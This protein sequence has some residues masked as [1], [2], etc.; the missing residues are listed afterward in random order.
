MIKKYF[1]L[2]LVVV[3]AATANAQQTERLRFSTTVGTGVSMSS[4]KSTPFEWQV[5]GHY[6]F[7]R[8]FSAG[9]GT[10]LSFYEK[11]LI[12]L[13]ADVKFAL[14]RP[15]KFT[16]FLECGA[17]Y[18]FA[19]GKHVK[20]GVYLNP[21]AGVQYSVC[22]RRILFIALGYELQKLE[23]LK[24]YESPLFTAELAEK[25]NHSSISVKAGFIF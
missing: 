4:P 24:K 25:L 11:T 17:G 5:L 19:P 13:F 9:I 12:P 1:F 21:S 3:V 20:G 8:R 14:I 7:N 15:R 23:R 2:L 22:R 16:P 18:S 6:C 10:G